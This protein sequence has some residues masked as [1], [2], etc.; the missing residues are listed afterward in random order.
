M[1]AASTAD[2]P[3]ATPES[4]HAS[5][6]ATVLSGS[7]RAGRT[8]EATYAEALQ[9]VDELQALVGE[10][11]GMVTGVT[12]RIESMLI[13]QLEAADTLEAARDHLTDDSDWWGVASRSGGV[14]S[15][16]PVLDASTNGVLDAGGSVAGFE[17][18]A[19]LSRG[20]SPQVQPPPVVHNSSSSN[21]GNQYWRHVDEDELQPEWSQR[22]SDWSQRC[23]AKAPSRLRIEVPPL[24][25]ASPLL[26]VAFVD[27]N[28][29]ELHTRHE[30]LITLGM[31][32]MAARLL[33]LGLEHPAR[34]L[35]QFRPAFDRMALLIQGSFGWPSTVLVFVVLSQVG[36]LLRF[37]D[38]R[39]RSLHELPHFWPG[40]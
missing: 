26:L 8:D 3:N 4:T 14:H 15:S 21:D 38:G 30:L 2:V 19:T 17:L 34:M 29:N 31:I 39:A 1:A 23:C 5:E 25:A 18:E 36:G 20:H 24:L 28:T 35:I 16:S 12:D 37:D 27:V 10:S 40:A 7:G 22:F 32:Y 33:T 9:T 13:E 11:P 6:T